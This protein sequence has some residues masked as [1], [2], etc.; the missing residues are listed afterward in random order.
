MSC[1][2]ASYGQ[3]PLLR[4]VQAGDDSVVKAL[5]R[6]EPHLDVNARDY[7]GR[8]P[9]PLAAENSHTAVV[10]Q[11]LKHGANPNWQDLEQVV[12]L[13]YASHGGHVVVV[14]TTRIPQLVLDGLAWCGLWR[15]A[16][17]RLQQRAMS[18]EEVPSD[19]GF[20][21]RHYVLCIRACIVTARLYTQYNTH[22]KR[23]DWK[24]IVAIG[25]PVWDGT[26]Y[27]TRNDY[28]PSDYVRPRENGAS[29][30]QNWRQRFKEMKVL[31]VQEQ[32]PPA[33]NEYTNWERVGLLSLSDISLESNI[34]ERRTLMM[35]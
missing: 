17:P 28:S 7:D 18:E 33:A 32:H 21:G 1:V 14:S 5:L 6:A 11:L 13:W 9:L 31:I 3:T 8:T 10:F 24:G 19:I 15:A 34:L 4:A 35:M 29:V 25:D 30:V 22:E 16:Q 20:S 27:P 2:Q 23:H 26:Y 12:P